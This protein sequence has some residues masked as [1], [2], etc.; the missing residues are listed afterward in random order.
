MELNKRRYSTNETLPPLSKDQFLEIFRVIEE[1]TKDEQENI[2]L[3]RD[4]DGFRR[5]S[6]ARTDMTSMYT[7]LQ[8]LGYLQVFGAATTTT[9]SQ[10][11]IS[12]STH[13]NPS[14]DFD[15]SNTLLNLPAQGSKIVT[16]AI[17]ETATSLPLSALT[18][19][20]SNIL[21]L[22][23]S[24][25]A[26]GEIL[27]GIWTGIDINILLLSTISFIV[28]DRIFFSGANVETLLRWLYPDSTRKIIHHEAG[29]FL[30]AYLLGCPV[31]G[32]VL[33]T[34]AALKDS[35]FGGGTHS[36]RFPRSTVSAGTSF[37]DP[38][39]SHEMNLPIPSIRRQ[40]IDK[41]SI[42]V[43]G[44]IAAEAMVYGNAEGGAGDEAQLI[45]FLSSLYSKATNGDWRN[46]E[47]IKNQARFGVL[48]AVSFNHFWNSGIFYFIF[49]CELLKYPCLPIFHIKGIIAQ[50]L[51]ILL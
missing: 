36:N 35:R 17:L 1:Q 31:E 27:V 45:S 8:S 51:S 25:V 20:S 29:H 43:M 3:R 44:G 26:L 28:L 47:L 10:E 41:Y 6:T 49:S 9:R 39:L 11:P 32:M 50:T 15:T 4:E 14:N 30:L 2:N 22:A 18:P 12:I 19:K 13:V 7:T 24:I 34:W 5:T 48:Q 23:G 42:I 16:P 21:F 37:F 40:S 33:S 46:I 38:Q